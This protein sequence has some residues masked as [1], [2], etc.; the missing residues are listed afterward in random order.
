MDIKLNAVKSLQTVLDILEDFGY[1]TEDVTIRDE[2]G[3][4]EIWVL[5]HGYISM[6][7]RDG[8]LDILQFEYDLEDALIEVGLF[9][10]VETTVKESAPDLSVR[11]NIEFRKRK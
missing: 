5:L 3:F 4:G 7:G 9:H 6:V 10:Y 8:S 1:N 2:S 11:V